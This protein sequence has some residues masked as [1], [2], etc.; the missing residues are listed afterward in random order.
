MSVE[1]TESMS[2]IWPAWQGRA[3]TGQLRLG[4]YLGGSDHSAVFLTEPAATAVKLVPAIPG[5][6]EAQL[7]DWERAAGLAHPHL[8]HLFETGRCELDGEP[9]LY[10]VMEYA[11]QN[12]AQ[13]L[14]HRA[15]S[16]DEARE[17]LPPT[18]DA[19]GFLH[20]RN[21]VHGQ[22]K[23]ANILAVGD[24]LKLAADTVRGVREAGANRHVVSTYDP[25]E[26]RYGSY[27][28]AGDIWGLG[29]TLC[30][31]LT[32]SLPSGLNDE[33]A[34]VTLPPGFPTAFRE[35]TARCL[36]R[37][38]FDRPKVVEVEAWLRRGPAP[39]VPGAG[40]DP[41]A[42]P[43]PAAA[44]EPASIPSRSPQPPAS[45]VPAPAVEPA[46]ARAGG[47][48]IAA[49]TPP[50]QRSLVSPI[51]AAL[52]LVVLTWIGI[53][54]LLGT[55]PSPAPS[56]AVPAEN[57]QASPAPNPAPSPPATG[58]PALAAGAAALPA[59]VHEEIP[60][61][62]L[63]ARETIHGHIRVSVRVIVDQD[64]NVVATLLDRAGPSRYFARLATSAAGKWTF[65]PAD[66]AGR[67]VKLVR[68]EF[69]RQGTQGSAAPVE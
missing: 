59:V 16:E 15:L 51:V 66:S 46:I 60:N 24:R 5:F 4:R 58:A 2:G 65:P 33:R 22:L 12:L 37:R 6:A 67:R 28:A 42:Q 18:L 19:L 26:A 7:A 64:G 41:A 63:H 3:I 40:R 56:A 34:A 11:D 68:F 61:V 55:H 49:P 25:P 13:L 57:A 30:E 47:A 27:S 50:T 29:L 43:A 52:V 10:A 45:A 38:P 39:G 8:I 32:R 48:G 14:R 54:M 20:G 69:T 21:L 36:S 44:P 62:P 1:P 53:R 31:A 23:P 17:V 9:Y 35:M